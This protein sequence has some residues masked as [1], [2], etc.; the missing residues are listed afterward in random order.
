MQQVTEYDATI[1]SGTQ[2]RKKMITK[3]KVDISDLM[4]I[5]IWAMLSITLV[6]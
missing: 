5:I 3:G 1:I 2:P 6:V 4:M